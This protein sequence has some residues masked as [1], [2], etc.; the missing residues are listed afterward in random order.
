ML[1]ELTRKSIRVWADF[2]A[3]LTRTEFIPREKKTNTQN[4][5]ELV[6]TDTHTRTRY[7]V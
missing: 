2:T 4:L 6:A 3:K 7:A 5:D 1:M